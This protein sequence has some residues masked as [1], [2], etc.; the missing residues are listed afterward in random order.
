MT[1]LFI[2]HSSQDR[3]VAEQIR[4]DLHNSGFANLFLDVDPDQG[5]APGA[6]WERE[7]YARLRMADAVLF[8]G[9]PASIESRWCFAELAMAR[10]VGKPI[11]PIVI[12]EPGR[13]PLL[14]DTQAME[15]QVGVPQATQQ[16]LSHLA[17]HGLDSE[18]SLDWD[19]TRS[20]YP[21]L[22]HF[23]EEDAG[24]FFGRKRE[25]EALMAKLHSKVREGGS[26]CVFGPSGSGKSSLVRAGLIPRLRRHDDWLILS[27]LTPKGDPFRNLARSLAAAAGG[28]SVTVEIWERLKADGA[29]ALIDLVERLRDASPRATSLLLVID[30]AEELVTSVGPEQ[31][32]QFLSLLDG[33][34]TN[35]QGIWVIATIRS[36]FVTASPD[37]AD[38]IGMMDDWLPVA[39][40]DRSRLA[41]VIERPATQAGLTFDD[42]LIARIVEETSGGDALP[43]LGYTLRQLADHA[44]DGRIT[45]SDYETIGG[46]GGAVG[47]VADH[48]LEAFQGK[49]RAD[50]ITALLKLV[51]ISDND[52]PTRRRT[53]LARFGD[54]QRAI[55]KPFIDARLLTVS[56][57]RD[58]PSA[59][60]EVAHEALLRQWRPLRE[61]I[62]VRRDDVRIRSEV[63][64]LARDWDNA[65]RQ[66]SYLLRGTRLAQAERLAE[67][68]ASPFDPPAGEFVAASQDLAERERQEATKRE[69]RRRVQEQAAQVQALLPVRPVEGLALAV[70]TVGRSLD[71]LPGEL[72]A[73]AFAGLHTALG[74]ARERSVLAAHTATVLSVAFAPDGQE[75]VSAGLD[76]TLRLWTLTEPGRGGQLL[77]RHDDDVTAVAYSPDGQTIASASADQSVRL[78]SRSGALLHELP[79]P[80]RIN[81]VAW[82]PDGTAIVSAGADR[83]LRLWDPTGRQLGGPLTGHEDDVTAVAWSPDGTTIVSAERRP[84]PATLG[85]HRPPARRA[86]DRTRGRRHRG[87]VEPG[88]NHDRQRQRRPDP[89]TLGPHRPP[90]RTTVRRT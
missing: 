88:R 56:G 2:S 31:R 81:A 46:V 59:F 85:P 6:N 82:S 36:E 26:V 51:T 29:P 4:A 87:G 39:A 77:A 1:S 50:A 48:I 68:D 79:H 64:R 67:L 45:A 62:D 90:A 34:G 58:E 9:S 14:T 21:G 27:P 53:S 76:R 73:P 78:W 86:T 49:D 10:S 24:V 71:A 30:Q 69:E 57:E 35:G 89:A 65:R 5:I 70:A 72:M 47:H 52:E 12:T 42:G 3:G 75:L 41:E 17:R 43:L 25:I 7:I 32:G 66:E 23:D 55:L 28:G 18:D 19:P 11:V 38:L 20:P 60:V 44:R 84:D 40:L 15:F 74:V 37:Y 13:H 80:E 22:A 33:L 61:A 83:T 8:L 16:L 63:E 54:S